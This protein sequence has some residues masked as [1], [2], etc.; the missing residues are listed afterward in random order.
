MTKE[1][2]QWLVGSKFTLLLVI[3]IKQGMTVN[4]EVVPSILRPEVL[5]NVN[6]LQSALWCCL[7]ITHL[8]IRLEPEVHLEQYI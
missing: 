5:M 1:F 3:I 7:F 2:C 8:P 6:S 4:R